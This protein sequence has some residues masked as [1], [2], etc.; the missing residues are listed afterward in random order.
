MSK[1]TD[2]EQLEKQFRELIETDKAHLP[3]LAEAPKRLGS[4]PPKLV[5]EEVVR[6]LQSQV[7]QLAEEHVFEPGLKLSAVKESLAQKISEIASAMAATGYETEQAKWLVYKQHMLEQADE[8]SI[9]RWDNEVS[10]IYKLSPPNAGKAITDN[11]P[12]VNFVDLEE[13]D[14]AAEVYPYF[15]TPQTWDQ[16]LYIKWFSKMHEEITGDPMGF[17]GQ[18]QRDKQR[19]QEEAK[20]KRV[21]GV[22]EE[23]MEDLVL[24][25][26]EI[27]EYAESLGFAAMGVTKLDRRYIAENLDDDL[28]Y[29]NLILL[30][31]E[32]P[33]EEFRKIPTDSPIVAFT[34]YRDGG[35]AIH[36][37]ADFI[38]SKGHKCLARVSSDGAIKYAPHAVNAGMGNYSTF[39]ICIFPEVG[40]RAKVAGIIME[41]E[42]PLD[43]PRDWNIEEIC[44]RCRCC[45]KVCPAGAIP[46]DEKRFRGTL[47][48]QTYH[49]RCFEYMATSYECNLCTRICPFSVVGH[50]QLMRALPHYYTYNLYRDDMDREQLQRPWE[51][52]IQ[53]A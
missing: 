32:M 12:Y 2:K 47:K 26:E 20:G 40:M 38:R 50:E 43:Q 44:S 16:E 24:L 27:R 42:L 52:E 39:G 17:I 51:P 28:P 10:K 1:K 31:H 21:P 53:D 6:D 9:Y 33:L 8:T 4:G 18:I 34:S 37:V 49:Q 45:Q 13:F 29:D 23:K 35:Q 3:R 7:R 15:E 36:K 19:M 22:S 41:T 46:R 25:K 30:A 11:N 48:R 14:I 5:R